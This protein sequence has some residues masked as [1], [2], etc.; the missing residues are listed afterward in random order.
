[1]NQST[2]NSCMH[3]RQHYAFDQRKIFRVHCGHCTCPKVKTKW[4]DS[5]ICENYVQSDPDEEFFVSKEFLS[6]VLLEYMLKLELL[7]EIHSIEY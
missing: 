2:C 7:P 6:K 3:Y 5:K 1:M 4:P